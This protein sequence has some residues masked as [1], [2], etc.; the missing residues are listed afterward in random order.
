MNLTAQRK[1]AR[2]AALDWMNEQGI[3]VPESFANSFARFYVK[4]T[5]DIPGRV[6]WADSISDFYMAFENGTTP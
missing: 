1:A 6:G 3:S 2:T 5:V 4:Y